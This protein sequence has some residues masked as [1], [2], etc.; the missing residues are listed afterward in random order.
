MSVAN[1]AKSSTS[2]YTPSNRLPTN[3]SAIDSLAL[4][5][6]GPTRITGRSSTTT[7]IA[8]GASSFGGLPGRDLF[9]GFGVGRMRLSTLGVTPSVFSRSRRTS[10]RAFLQSLVD[11]SPSGSHTKSLSFSYKTLACSSFSSGVMVQLYY[12]RAPSFDEAL[13]DLKCFRSVS[14][15]RLRRREGSSTWLHVNRCG[16][17]MRSTMYAT[18]FS[19]FML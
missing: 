15:I 4:Y 11:N 1:F 13:P 2:L 12:K 9:G 17:P 19:H 18:L 8:A 5:H 10:A 3:L 16:S 14:T 6:V 7:G